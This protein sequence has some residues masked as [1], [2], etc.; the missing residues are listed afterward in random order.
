MR[1]P[2]P[3]SRP[4]WS[5]WLTG[6]SARAL[7]LAGLL[8]AASAPAPAAAEPAPRLEDVKS[9]LRETARDYRA[10]LERLLALREAAL[11]R[12]AATAARFRDLLA[13]GVVSRREADERERAR[14]EAETR[15]AE[16]RKQLEEADLALGEALAMLDLAAR[17]P[18]PDRPGA[19]ATTIR[20]AGRRGDA[21][22]ELSV[23]ER[24]FVAR[25]GRPLPISALGQSPLHD[26]MG[27]D[28]RHAVDVAVHPDTPEGSGLMAFLRER[29]IAFLAFRQALAG[30]ASGAHIH[31]GALSERLA[32]PVRRP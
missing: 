23:I 27:L 18:E 30:A 31:I 29:G 24:F 20:F 1:E 22:A 26:R 16:T 25:F 8:G 12:E 4:C 28:H 32:H 19:P 11:A 14:A 9:E 2:T 5:C 7:L 17:P 15:V 13:Q 6:R 21:V 10:S 3:S